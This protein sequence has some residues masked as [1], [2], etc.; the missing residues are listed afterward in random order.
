MS[1]VSGGENIELLIEKADLALYQAKS[2]GRNCIV[3]SGTP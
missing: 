3:G 1:T 2:G